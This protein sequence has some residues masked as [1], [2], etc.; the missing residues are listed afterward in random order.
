MAS[1]TTLGKPSAQLDSTC[2]SRPFITAGTSS[3][4]PASTIRSARPNRSIKAASSAFSPVMPPHQHATQARI[5]AI[6]HQ[7]GHRAQQVGVV[8][9]GSQRATQPISG[10][11]A[12]T[13]Q[14]CRM[15]APACASG[16]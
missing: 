7:R 8:L 2:T 5:A 3:L 10:A 14:C 16:A 15:R 12:G 4:G 11:S 6:A 13:F 9:S 1:A